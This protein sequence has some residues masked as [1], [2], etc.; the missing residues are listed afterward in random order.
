MAVKK[1]T[2]DSTMAKVEAAKKAETKAVETKTA[3][4]K[5]PAKKAATKAEEKKTETKAVETKT[6]AKKAPAKKAEA[7][8]AA[9]KKAP[10]KK[11]PAKKAATTANVVI[12]YAGGQVATADIVAKAAEVS[13]KKSVKTLNVYYQPEN[14]MVYFT[15]DGEE[16]SFAL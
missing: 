7:K 10:A 12:E 11:A 4:K 1:A 2:V 5:A 16:G 13:G 6:A 15:A 8:P 9:E 3:A 14:G